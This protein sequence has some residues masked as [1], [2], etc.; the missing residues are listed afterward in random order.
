LLK[1]M[2]N[3]IERHSFSAQIAWLPGLR[4]SAAKGVSMDSLVALG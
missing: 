1:A 2:S 3:P 4:V